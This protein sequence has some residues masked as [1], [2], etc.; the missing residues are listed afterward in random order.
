MPRIKKRYVLLTYS[1]DVIPKDILRS[2]LWNAYLSIPSRPSNFNNLLLPLQPGYVVFSIP[3]FLIEDFKIAVKEE[4]S[5]K[6]SECDVIL[7][8][9]TIRALRKKAKT[10]LIANGYNHR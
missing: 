10:R 6:G 9:G 4:F 1:P 3:Y 7:V 5:K 2:V 8:S